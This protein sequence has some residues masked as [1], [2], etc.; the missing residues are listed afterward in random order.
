[1]ATVESIYNKI[2]GY[3]QYAGLSEAELY[4]IANELYKKNIYQTLSLFFKGQADPFS[5][6]HGE[7]A[8]WAQF[9]YIEIIQMEEQGVLIPEEVLA[10]AHSMQDADCTNYETSDSFSSDDASNIE[11]EN[12]ESSKESQLITLKKAAQAMIGQCEKNENDVS[13][14]A[15]TIDA[16]KKEA[17]SKKNQS[18]TLQREALNQIENIIDEWKALESKLKRNI[19][20]SETE[21]KRF[22]ELSALLNQ[23][24]KQYQNEMNSIDLDFNSI[25][26]E[27]NEIDSLNKNTDDLSRETEVIGKKITE[28]ESKHKYTSTSATTN[29]LT[30]INGVII[31]SSLSKGLAQTAIQA[32]ITTNQFS[33]DVQT[34]VNEVA[35]LIDL[36]T[37]VTSKAQ[38]TS[39]AQPQLSAQQTNNTENQVK[40]EAE[41]EF[42]DTENAQENSTTQKI[43][44]TTASSSVAPVKASVATQGT[45]GIA[46][47]SGITETSTSTVETDTLSTDNTEE[48]G[49]EVK[50][51]TQEQIEQCNARSA[52]ITNAVNNIDPL[53]K[54]VEDIQKESKLQSKIYDAKIEKSLK[55][56][57]TLCDKMRNGEKL[58][59]AEE[60][61]FKKLNSELDKTNG[62]Y[63]NDLDAKLNTLSTYTRSLNYAF[64][65][66]NESFELANTTVETGKELAIQELGDRS[67]LMKDFFF[68]LLNDER[69]KDLLYG[70]AGESLGRDAIDRGEVLA[71]QA[72]D[73]NTS[74]GRQVPIANFAQEEAGTITEKKNNF[75]DRVT[76]I[77]Q[78]VPGVDASAN[79]DNADNEQDEENQNG[80]KQEEFTDG[81]VKSMTSQA[82]QLTSETN[83]M[84]KTAEKAD[85]KAQKDAK[86]AEQTKKKY[87]QLNKQDE[88][89]QEQ[90]TQKVE[91][92]EAKIE[93][94]NAKV[95]QAYANAA[96]N[97][98][99]DDENQEPQDAVQ[100]QNVIKLYNN[101]VIMLL[102]DSS[103]A[104]QR[105]RRYKITEA[106]KIKQ[107]E[108]S[109]TN[110]QEQC[111][112]FEEIVSKTDKVMSWVTVGGIS[113]IGTG[114][115]LVLAGNAMLSNP[116]TAAAGTVL[117]AAGNV[118][119]NIGGLAEQAGMIGSLACKVVKAGIAIADG[120]ILGAL[121]NL[122]IA[123]AVVGGAALGG[124]A[125]L[126]MGAAGEVAGIATGMIDE[127]KRPDGKKD[128][129]KNNTNSN[130]DNKKRSTV[131]HTNVINNTNIVG[132]EIAKAA[133]AQSANNTINPA[134]AN[135]TE[136]PKTNNKNKKVEVPTTASASLKTAGQPTEETK[137]VEGNEEKTDKGQEVNA[138]N[139]KQAAKDA[140]KDSAANKQ[141]N[142]ESEENTRE[143]EKT[144]KDAQ[145]SDKNFQ[146]D[147]KKLGKQIQKDQKELEQTEKKVEETSNKIDEEELAISTLQSEVDGLISI[148]ESQAGA[149]PAAQPQQDDGTGA[150]HSG[151]SIMNEI[152]AA[153][154][155]TTQSD[156]ETK[157]Q[158]LNTQITTRATRAGLYSDKLVKFQT[159]S[160]KTI[161]R[162]KTTNKKYNKAV[163]KEQKQKKEDMTKSEKVLKTAEKI[164]EISSTVAT[165][166]FI[167][168]T[169]G[170]ILQKVVL[171]PWIPIVGAVMSPIGHTA[172]AIGNYGVAAANLTKTAVFAAQG[173]LTG[174]LMSAGMAIMAGA[175]AVSATGQATK[176][177]QNMGKN[178]AAAQGRA[179]IVKGAKETLKN[180]AANGLEKGM[181][182]GTLNSVKQA[183]SKMMKETLKKAGE[184]LLLNAP[185]I[186]K[187]AQKLFSK[188]KKEEKK[189]N[190]YELS[191]RF[192]KIQRKN[193]KRRTN[194]HKKRGY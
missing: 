174:A 177:F 182:Q 71:Q 134:G 55:E 129:E 183:G 23:E 8:S 130:T 89:Q 172:E 186:Q 173:N 157:I 59:A 60:G 49:N 11:Q 137:A 36:T 35:S 97:A 4:D 139:G 7:N 86:Y 148:E 191:D 88:A 163:K 162:M 33:Q 24:T 50:T 107:A 67:Y 123:G 53:K 150:V 72:T 101:E 164:E 47:G 131:K 73:A 126:A 194:I 120:D 20:L 99:I 121:K 124:V 106:N 34:E 68:M 154:S 143:M 85:V 6:F 13:S 158:D 51:Q 91:V 144:D 54:A 43:K 65:I 96:T 92:L 57:E 185:N 155:T 95:E 111:S 176:G 46:E 187:T 37:N 81:D 175:S 28:S 153:P 102:G 66:V 109:N 52:E 159:K 112:K 136:Q 25:A 161:K 98:S 58:S 38:A 151:F 133:A 87:D 135:T 93:E 165:V 39:S 82:N 108:N 29:I 147:S 181:A 189:K 56:Y 84:G 80:E 110:A 179:A 127:N 193:A 42:Q 69:Q 152:T 45:A 178:I 156:N 170:D 190:T 19:P 145:K 192:K 119:I 32:G 105:L 16:M 113:L 21:Q 14:Q 115:G 125:G 140:Q 167:V 40:Q 128:E 138:K 5:P 26:S 149:E 184:Q 77:T 116:F 169:T 75:V 117:I 22:D 78:D 27:L 31:S 79:S 83:A 168:G 70:K 122:A 30:G 61:T 10:W 90:T 100:A 132:G 118:S 160:D 63:V 3:T 103:R 41:N 17:E 64:D 74:L 142:R 94:E 9:T 114:V 12:A 44:T 1:M 18:E 104:T 15:D 2:K 48:S 62:N 166:G 146:K 141:K 76:K 188:D 180:A 171:P